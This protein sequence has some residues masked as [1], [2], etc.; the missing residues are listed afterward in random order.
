MASFPHFLMERNINK[1]KLTES[2][3]QM[4]SLLQSFG[5]HQKVEEQIQTLEKSHFN[6]KL[7][8]RFID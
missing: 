8:P 3:T 5:V 2:F 6:N 4:E 1:L 7:P